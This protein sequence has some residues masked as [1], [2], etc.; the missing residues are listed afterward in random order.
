LTYPRY[1][2]AHMMV[3]GAYVVFVAWVVAETVGVTRV[4]KGV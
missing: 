2:G 3:L 4:L 1:G